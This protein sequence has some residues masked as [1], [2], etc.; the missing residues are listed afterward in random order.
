[1][2][3]LKKGEINIDIIKT[4]SID[5][6]IRNIDEIIYDCIDKMTDYNRG[7]LSETILKS[8]RDLIE[9]TAIK[10]LSC[11]KGYEM[12]LKHEST[13]EA[14]NFIKDRGQ[15]KFLAKFHRFVQNAVGHRTPTY[16]NAE[17]LML[18]YFE[19][20]LKL[21]NFYKDNFN[22]EILNNINKFPLNTDNTYYEY[23]GE[24]AN[25]IRNINYIQDTK[26]ISGRYYVQKVK[27]FF[28]NNKI[29]YEVTLSPAVDNPSKFARVTMY[30]KCEIDTNYSIRIAVLKEV[31]N[32]FGANTDIQII[33]K[34][35]ISI[36]PCEITNFYK[37]FGE[38][39]EF[40]ASYKEYREIMPFLSQMNYNFLD[41]I[42]MD[43]LRYERIKEHFKETCRTN[44]IITLIDKCR[45]ITKNNRIGTNIIRYLVFMLNNSVIKRQLWNQSNNKLSGMFLKYGCLSFEEMPFVTSLIKHNP[46]IY[47]LFECLDC[48]N[49]QDELL[50]RYIETNTQ[51]NGCLYTKRSEVDFF[52]DFDNLVK[53]YNSKLY[54]PKHKNREL[55]IDGEN[56]YIRGYEEDT[57]K[58]LEKLQEMS[59]EGIKGY[60]NSVEFW[61]NA[62]TYYIDDDEK[63]EV[64]KNLFSSSKVALIYGAAGT[65]KTTM[66]N[67]ISNY[68]NNDRKIY[69]ANTHP[70]V[71]NLK[72]KVSAQNCEFYTVKRILSNGNINRDCDILIIDECSTVSNEDMIQLLTKINFE[73]LVLVGDIYQIE[74]ITFGN[75]FGISKMIINDNAKYELTVPYRSKNENLKILWD[76]VRNL[77]DEIVEWL[78]INRYSQ[79]LDENILTKNEEDEIILCL[80][81]D[82][83]YGINNINRF[84][85]NSNRNISVDWGIGRYKVGD[86]ILFNESNRFAP[87]IYNNL[88]GKIKNIK[89][90]EFEHKIWFDIEIDMVIDERDANLVGLQLIDSNEKKST[91]RF[92]VNEFK[93]LDEDDD[94]NSNSVV[95]FF[96]AYA[97]SIHK[98][99]GLEYNSVKIIITQEIEENISHNIFYTAI[100][101]AMNKLKIYWTPE[102]QDRI[103][104]NMK[105]KFNAKDACIVRKKIKKLRGEN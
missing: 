14:I 76:K 42:D 102:C 89:V 43:K 62:G 49:R 51:Q 9:H 21:K 100:T 104:K 103:I 69:L 16:D 52:K 97:V 98:S 19:Y 48:N 72:R 63:R 66:I 24:I 74:S 77:D 3:L 94:I 65:G 30:T 73:L 41:L 45:N 68:F 46:K 10:V 44:Y 64:L 71:E 13:V 8:L 28:I 91:V 99:Q 93:E 7:F 96:I 88:K 101:R 86:P 50:A 34:W 2:I 25:K 57:I 23:Y 32:I 56:I 92:Y 55:V 67:H 6:E 18:K 70:A 81:Y 12:E 78:S 35:E 22:M 29:Y 4:D 82:G 90:N 58:I 75:W 54:L 61:L 84:M 60:S 36:R 79:R 33:T 11:S 53:R 38:N 95:P 17:R 1:M 39:I 27:P 105:F 26:F 15:Y 80:N 5:L 47:D 83:L 31:A 37:I 20:L 59:I 85:Q 87:V 40:S